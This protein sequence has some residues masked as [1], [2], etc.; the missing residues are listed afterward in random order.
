MEYK[1]R[2]IAKPY[3]HWED[4]SLGGMV[5]STGNSEVNMTGGWRV[6]KPIIEWDKCKQCLMCVPICPDSSIPVRDKLRLDFDYDHCKGCGA[7]VAACPFNA[8]TMVDEEK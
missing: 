4:L 6:K 8:I 1:D 5:R 3:T 2:D 7:C